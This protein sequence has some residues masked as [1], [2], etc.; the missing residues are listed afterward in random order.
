MERGE[1]LNLATNV[2]TCSID[3][4]REG[5]HKEAVPLMQQAQGVSLTVASGLPASVELRPR[6]QLPELAHPEHILFRVG[7]GSLRMVGCDEGI[8]QG[9]S[10]MRRLHLIGALCGSA[11]SMM[12]EGQ[13]G[14]C[15]VDI[16]DGGDQGDYSRFAF[17]AATGKAALLPDPF[18]FSSFGYDELRKAV[19]VSAPAWRD[20]RDVIFWRGGA[21]GLA[22]AWPAPGEPLDFNCLQRLSLCAK[23]ARIGGAGRVDVGLTAFDQISRE[24]I[25]DQIRAAGLVRETVPKSE[26]VFYRYLIDIDGNSN[27]WS[28]FEKL[29]MGAAIL[30]VASPQGFR[31]WYYDRLV[32]WE[33]FVPVAAD[34]SDF[35]DRVNWLFDHPA[36]AEKIGANAAEL[37]RSLNFQRVMLEAQARFSLGLVKSGMALV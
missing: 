14:D 36:E 15:I 37:A 9:V 10:R 4:E 18:F 8:S 32:P 31:Q 28:L 19:A 5:R 25:R 2:A 3:L 16:G 6:G 13:S 35:E 23:A 11:A 22:A 17:S 7:R 33:H 1:L 20:R 26:F 24:D 27:S 34:L 12:P 30:K 21:S 29:I